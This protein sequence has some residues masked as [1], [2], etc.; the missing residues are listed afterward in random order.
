MKKCN[1][2]GVIAAPNM[3]ASKGGGKLRPECKRCTADA[4]NIYAAKNRKVLAERSKLF[5]QANPEKTRAF[6]AGRNKKVRQKTRAKFYRAHRA[7][8]LAASNQR[9]AEK[10]EAILA[11]RKIKYLCC[12]EQSRAKRREHR[13]NHPESVR[14]SDHKKRAMRLRAVGQST[15]EQL[16]ARVSYY[17]R[18]C[19]YCGGPYE[20]LDH[21]IP[22]SRGGT[23][24]PANLR[25]ACAPCNMQKHT[26]KLSEW[27]RQ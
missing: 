5:R 26:R 15:A 12:I 9:Y 4:Q 14:A 7:K 20:H 25:P 17:G 2:C 19:A 24:W 18:R 27:T 13:K 1:R 8:R 22:L 11:Q 16:E 10:R 21:V 3:F 23:N 6:E